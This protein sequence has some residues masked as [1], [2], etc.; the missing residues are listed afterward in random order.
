M[1]LSRLVPGGAGVPR[2]DQLRERSPEQWRDMGAL[3]SQEPVPRKSVMGT[4][5]GV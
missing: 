3:V 4:A 5:M 2:W 1:G